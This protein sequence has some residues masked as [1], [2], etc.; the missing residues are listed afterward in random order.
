[1]DPVEQQ[2]TEGGKV[3]HNAVN[4]FFYQNLIKS[5]GLCLGI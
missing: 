1:M 5:T 3:I 4:I 2:T